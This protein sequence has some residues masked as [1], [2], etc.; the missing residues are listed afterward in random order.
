[1][2]HWSFS[3]TALF[4]LL[5]GRGPDIERHQMENSEDEAPAEEQQPEAR[6]PATAS[7]F[8]VYVFRC[9]SVTDQ[10]R[11]NHA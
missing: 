4:P 11:G 3:R 8:E 6:S 2:L 1:M 5:F 10:G 7:W 9:Y